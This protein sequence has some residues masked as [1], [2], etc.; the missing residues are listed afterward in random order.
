MQKKNNENLALWK[1]PQIKE[2]K[3]MMP[4]DTFVTVVI[5]KHQNKVISKPI[6]NQFMKGLGIVVIRVITKQQQQELLRDI[7]NLFITA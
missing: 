7:R 3:Q 6:S 5:M 1:G 2:K 4:V